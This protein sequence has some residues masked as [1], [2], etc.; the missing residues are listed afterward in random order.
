MTEP[1]KPL[2]VRVAEALGFGGIVCLEGAWTMHCPCEQPHCDNIL[3]VPRYDTDW[4]ATG[5]LIEKYHIHLGEERTLST[6]GDVVARGQWFAGVW[7]S[8]E[9]K[10][11]LMGYGATPLIAV[12]NLLVK[13]A[14]NR[15]LYVKE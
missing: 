10:D 5:P 4:S 7:E 8:D 12:C 9:E 15:L 2:H 1:E 6:A 14:E 3:D 11:Y 13:L